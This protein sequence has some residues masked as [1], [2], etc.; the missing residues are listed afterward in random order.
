M[1]QGLKRLGV[2]DNATGAGTGLRAGPL[3][4]PRPKGM[5]FIGVELDSISG[6]I[7]RA[8]HPE[9]GHPHREFPRHQPARDR[10]GDR[11]RALRRR[12]AR[13]PR[14]EVL[15]ARL[16]LRQVHRRPQARRRAGAG[17][18]RISRS[19]SRMP[20]SA[21]TWP[22]R[23]ISS[24]RSACPPT[25][26]SAKARPWSP[27]SCSCA[28]GHRGEPASHAD[29]DWLE[30]EPLDID[31]MEMPINRYFLH[32]PGNGAGHLEPQGHALRRRLQRHRQRRSGRAA[33][34]GDSTACR[35]SHRFEVSA[36][37]RSPQP[38]FTPPPP[39]RH[40]SEG[41]FFVGDDRTI[42]QIDGRPGRARRLRR[43]A[44]SRPTAR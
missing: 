2:P 43:H 39:Q 19:T 14:P 38:S 24:E 11:Q 29:P 20:P 32:H 13:L 4:P 18:D 40:I 6:R 22:S 34:R 31:G 5:R 25:P 42:C 28:S 21:S 17:H 33:P 41:S 30:T 44:C 9:P 27:T 3:S 10:R 7:A 1:Y 26:S 16:F 35:N 23:R 37:A 36:A 12:E 15:A 8:L